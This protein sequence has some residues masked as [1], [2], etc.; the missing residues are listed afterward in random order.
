[1]PLPL[2]RRGE[3]GGEEDVSAESICD[4]CGKRAPKNVQVRLPVLPTD[5]LGG[6]HQDVATAKFPDG[7]TAVV[8][9]GFGCGSSEMY[10]SIGGK[11]RLAV[12]ASPLI[13]ALIDAAVD[14]TRKK[15]VAKR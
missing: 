9:A 5:R 2:L 8:S 7:T 13:R 1:L 4:G 10:V 14:G 11:R 12:D 6:F 3:G 15:K